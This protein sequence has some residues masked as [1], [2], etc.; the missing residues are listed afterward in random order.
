MRAVVKLLFFVNKDLMLLECELF[1]AFF[2]ELYWR[3]TYIN[4]LI[5]LTANFFLLDAENF[6]ISFSARWWS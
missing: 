4:G 5:M 1:I 3:T 2:V 6:E